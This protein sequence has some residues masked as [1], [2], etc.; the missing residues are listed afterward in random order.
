MYAD[1]EAARAVLLSPATK[2]LV[3]LDVSRRVVLTFEHLNRFPAA[4]RSRVGDFLH[5][6]IPYAFRA[7]HQY[8][9]VE[10]FPLHEVVALASI[11]RPSLFRSEMMA[12][13]IETEGELT[14][15]MTVFD[16][17]RIPQWQRNIEVITDVDV[18]GVLDYVFETLRHGE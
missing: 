9:G 12:L 2:T 5:R 3:P 17:R 7:H 10:G 11:T 8:L 14:R 15:G 18:Q 4:D 13:N 6:L 1:P 16:R